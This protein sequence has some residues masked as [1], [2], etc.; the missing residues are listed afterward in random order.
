MKSMHT[1]LLCA[2]LAAAQSAFAAPPA[3]AATVAGVQMPA[4]VERADGRRTPLAPGMELKAGELVRTGAQSRLLLKMAEGSLVKLGENGA[5]RLEELKADQGGVFRAA[6]KVAEGAFRFTTD[7][8]AKHRRRDINVLVSNVTVGI[9]GTDLWGKS[10]A[11]RQIVCLIEG[12]IEVRPEGEGTISMGEPLQFYIREGGK[13]LPL[14][15]VEPGQ[16]AIWAAETEIGAGRGAARSGGR[17]KVTLAS[18]DTQEAALAIY[19]RLRDNGYA[20]E[21]RP[22]KAGDSHVYDVRIAQL[23]SKAEAEALAGQ[24]QGRMGVTQTKVSL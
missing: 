5:L 19:D 9:R 10:E 20:A 16:L 24:L 11:N 12:R 17:W 3:P 7:A 22:V 13:S 1:L 2:A 21:I 14:A 6:M 18:V 23:P 8:L 4:W 15:R